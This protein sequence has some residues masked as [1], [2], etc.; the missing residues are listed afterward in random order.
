MFIDFPGLVDL[1]LKS[2][3]KVVEVKMEKKLVIGDVEG[4]ADGVTGNIIE[5]INEMENINKADIKEENIINIV[6][7]NSVI[8]R[9]ISEDDF[10]TVEISEDSDTS[11]HSWEAVKHRDNDNTA[12]MQNTGRQN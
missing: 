5:N 12:L 1:K 9:K 4:V 7:V 3:V 2:G 10:L 6:C 8:N 11:D